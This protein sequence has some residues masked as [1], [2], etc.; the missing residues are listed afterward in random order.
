MPQI[1]QSIYEII[2]QVIRPIHADFDIPRGTNE[3]IDYLQVGL[4]ALKDTGKFSGCTSSIYYTE[5]QL[6]PG[7]LADLVWSYMNVEEVC[8]HE[9]DAIYSELK[10][11]ISSVPLNAHVVKE[12]YPVAFAQK[13]LSSSV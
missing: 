7:R 10:R 13:I 1:S 12:V 11:A 6:S 9:V 5:R 8:N 2:E 3:Q 4:Q